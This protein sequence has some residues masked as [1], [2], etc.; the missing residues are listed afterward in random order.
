MPSK[1]TELCNMYN[2]AEANAILTN[3][4]LKTGS[5]FKSHKVLGISN[6][7]CCCVPCI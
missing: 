3:P 5:L 1:M 2:P 4:G 7:I 6:C